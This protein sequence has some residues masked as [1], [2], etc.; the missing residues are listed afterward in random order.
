MRP[1]P[2]RQKSSGAPRAGLKT[3]APGRRLTH[4]DARGR[5]KMVDVGG[6][7]VTD[8]EAVARGSI[9]SPGRP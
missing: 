4:T 1:S 8:R 2:A 9:R 5:I 3:A 7:P 6:K